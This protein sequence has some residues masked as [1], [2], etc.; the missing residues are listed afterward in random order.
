M[1]WILNYLIF[2]DVK[3]RFLWFA[4]VSK[5]KI[6]PLYNAATWNIRWQPRLHC[7]SMIKI[8]SCHYIW[9]LRSNSS[10]CGKRRLFA[11]LYIA[12]YLIAIYNLKINYG[13]FYILE[14]I[15]IYTYISGALEGGIELMI[16][17][18]EIIII[19]LDTK[20]IKL[21]FFNFVCETY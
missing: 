19:F 12:A 9:Q 8:E 10:C 20:Y 7:I 3:P 1:K 5:I 6:S 2:S 4:L 14:I 18:F 16:M 15:K 17:T 11:R 21:D 13:E